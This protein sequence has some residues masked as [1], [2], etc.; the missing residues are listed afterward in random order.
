[1]PLDRPTLPALRDRV[2]SDIQSA[3]GLESARTRGT[4]EH[5]LAKAMAAESHAQYGY[6]DAMVRERFV[7][8]CSAEGVYRFAAEYGVD[9]VPAYAAAG[10]VQ[11][12]GS[13]GAVVPEGT[14][15]ILAASGARYRVQSAASVVSGVAVAT[16]QAVE[17]G[18]AGNLVAGTSLVLASSVPGI[19]P[20][21]SVIAPGIAGGA[22]A[23]D[24]ERLRV[25]LLRYLRRPPQG[26][27]LHDFED[28]AFAAHPSVTRVWVT[29]HEG[30]VLGT[31]TVRMAT[32]GPSGPIP[33]PAV[34]D[35][36]RTYILDPVR[37]PAGLRAILVLAP[38]AEPVPFVFTGLSPDTP[39]VRAAI[40]RELDD[41][42]ARESEPGQLLRVSH[43]R[44]AIS[45]ADG[46]VDYQLSSP[47]AS[48]TPASVAHMLTRGVITWPT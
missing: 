17:P 21:A 28:W 15:M 4:V 38:I 46:E 43:L 40:Q 36:V 25:R 27:A 42:F 6:I 10:S 34:V 20:Q 23:E 12:D 8:T 32:D 22:E 41:V 33:A 16:V 24:V 7:S 14:E 37:R 18:V 26:G 47:A 29:E 13:P 31:V 39:A 5:A 48:L 30:D 2:A 45:I 35:A 44:E 1:M 3:S 9:P 19:A 11:L